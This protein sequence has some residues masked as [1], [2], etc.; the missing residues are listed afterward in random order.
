M[1]W[2]FSS[3]PLFYLPRK[4]SSARSSTKVT[5]T[6]SCSGRTSPPLQIAIDPPEH[7]ILFSSSCRSPPTSPSPPEAPRR[8]PTSTS[9]PKP[10]RCLAGTLTRWAPRSFFSRLLDLV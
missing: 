6:H 4:K 3:H 7:A 8:S 1:S 5:S 10:C 9:R 2:R